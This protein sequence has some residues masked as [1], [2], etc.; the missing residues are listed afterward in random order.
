MIRPYQEV[1]PI[2][3]EENRA[4]RAAMREIDE[5]MMSW[6][7]ENHVVSWY[8]LPEGVRS[9]LTREAVEDLSRLQEEFPR[10]VE[11]KHGRGCAGFELRRHPDAPWE[12]VFPLR[13]RRMLNVLCAISAE[14]GQWF[15]HRAGA[16]QPVPDDTVV[17]VRF[18]GSD[19]LTAPAGDFFWGNS[20]ITH[21]RLPVAEETHHAIARRMREF[22]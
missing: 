10:Y 14:P 6:L 7:P 8:E 11:V 22:C 3:E 18:W 2:L 4:L 9:R 1:A 5:A 13:T 20:T 15:E 16:P 17:E 12:Q 21:W 19:S